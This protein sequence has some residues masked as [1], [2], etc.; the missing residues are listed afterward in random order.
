VVVGA[1]LVVELALTQKAVAAL[2]L[3]QKAAAAAAE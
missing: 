1:L 3:T 2:A